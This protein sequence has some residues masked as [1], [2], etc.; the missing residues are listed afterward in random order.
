MVHYSF[1]NGE[2][3][4]DVTPASGSNVNAIDFHDARSG[5]IVDGNKTVLATDDGSSWER[6]GIANANANFY[7]VDSDGEADVT[8]AGGGGVVWNWDGSRWRPG[9]TGDATLRDVEVD[10]T[11]GITVG[12]GGTV[13]RRSATD[14]QQEATP[15]GQ[16][17]TAVLRGAD[18]GSS[19]D[20][21][22]GAGGT[23][24]ETTE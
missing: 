8:V 13:F 10:G 2:T 16:N 23:V 9:D 22:V 3:W 1:D 24:I 5:H 6:I 15:T 7:G 11:P 18:S 12:S 17:L 14:W 20:I 21:A 19:P 4:D